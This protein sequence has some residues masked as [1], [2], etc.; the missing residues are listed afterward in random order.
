MA[1]LI[2]DVQ[3]IVGVAHGHLVLLKGP[4]DPKNA[5]LFT[6]RLEALVDRGAETV[7]LNMKDVPYVNSSGLAFLIKLAERLEKR[8]FM[9]LVEVQPKVKVVMGML[10]LDDVFEILPSFK[11]AMA[12]RE[13]TLG[14]SPATAVQAA[15]APSRHL[16]VS[17]TRYPALASPGMARSGK[18]MLVLVDLRR[19]APEGEEAP[20]GL[21]IAGL[22]VDWK[23]ETLHVKLRSSGILFSPGGDEGTLLLG[24][25]DSISRASFSGLVSGVTKEGGHL[26]VEATFHRNGRLLGVARRKFPTA[27]PQA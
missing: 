24:R 14:V 18:P 9:A 13:R 5:V 17:A 3:D 22:P 19:E 16:G 21:R 27:A 4:I 15:A 6:G 26:E 11:D 12:S 8:G 2:V 1:D 10:G 23:Q 25:Q 20:E 7:I